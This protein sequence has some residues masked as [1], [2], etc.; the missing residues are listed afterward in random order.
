[1]DTIADKQKMENNLLKFWREKNR[2]I[3]KFKLE[4]TTFNLVE[5][6]QR[7]KNLVHTFEKT[8]KGKTSV[9]NFLK[10]KVKLL[11]CASRSKL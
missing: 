4:E 10:R 8:K 9:C 3:Q 2:N 7:D 11:K 5:K 6:K 1:M